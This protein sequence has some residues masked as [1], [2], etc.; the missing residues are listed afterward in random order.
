MGVVINTVAIVMI[1]NPLGNFEKGGIKS[2]EYFLPV[3]RWFYTI[4]ERKK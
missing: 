4:F 3:I 2:F 1:Q